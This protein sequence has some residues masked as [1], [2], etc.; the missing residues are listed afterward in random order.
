MVE[1]DVRRGM[2]D[3]R[4][5]GGPQV[6]APLEIRYKKDTKTTA[7]KTMTSTSPKVAIWWNTMAHG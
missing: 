4:V 3:R 6:S 2:P 5:L 1:S 7:A